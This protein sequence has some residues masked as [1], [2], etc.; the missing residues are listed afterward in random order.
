[1]I[2][3]EREK[4]NVSSVLGNHQKDLQEL[5]VET[6]VY[7]SIV[8]ND[9]PLSSACL[10]LPSLVPDQF[11]RGFASAGIWCFILIPVACPYHEG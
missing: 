7:L 5:E 8:A 9:S 2:N 1:M 11:R 4:C 3:L 10:L 6:R